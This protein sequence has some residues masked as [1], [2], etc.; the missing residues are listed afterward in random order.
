MDVVQI[1]PYYSIDMSRMRNRM[2]RMFTHAL[3][4]FSK[5][6]AENF[7]IGTMW[8]VLEKPRPG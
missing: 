2:F 5:V 7:F 8:A 3:M 1:D 6:D 4:R